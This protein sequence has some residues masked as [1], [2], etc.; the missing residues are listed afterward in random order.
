MAVWIASTFWLLWIM[1]LWTFMYQ[2]LWRHM[3]SIILCMYPG[4]EM[5]D[6]MAIQYLIFW[7]TAKLFS[8]QL[9]S[10]TFP[11]ARLESSSFPHPCQRVLMPF[12][13]YYY[14]HPSIVKCYLIMILICLSLMLPF[15]VCFGHLDT[16]FRN[17]S[18]SVLCSF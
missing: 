10:S 11:P 9:C 16:F 15:H 5:L 17:L 7:R 6:R 18:I 3:F 2:F 12:Y 8:L 4:V 14:I 13:Y 1:L